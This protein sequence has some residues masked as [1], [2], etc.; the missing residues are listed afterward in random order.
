MFIAYEDQE[1][2]ISNNM[3]LIKRSINKIM[4]NVLDTAQP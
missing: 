2:K 3:K 4:R 1:Y